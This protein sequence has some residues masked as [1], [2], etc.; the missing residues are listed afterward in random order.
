MGYLPEAL[1]NYLGRLGWSLDDK[2]EFIP[3]DQMIANFGLERVNDSPASF[4]PDKLSWLAGEYMKVLP[5]DRKVEGVL[6]FL[7]GPA[8]SATRLIRNVNIRSS[9]W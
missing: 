8:T 3:L 2:T 9:S 5:L 1:V 4:D 7:H 6:P